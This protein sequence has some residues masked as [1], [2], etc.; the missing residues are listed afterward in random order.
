MNVRT[1]LIIGF[2]VIVILLWLIAFFTS[3]SY[4]NLHQQFLD[5][6]EEIISETLFITNIESLASET[7]LRTLNY[8][9]RGSEGAKLDTISLLDRL[10]G[11]EE[12]GPLHSGDIEQELFTAIDQFSFAI[13]T[14]ITASDNG[15]AFEDLMVLDQ[16]VGLPALLSL[17]QAA[18]AQKAQNSEE[19]AIANTDFNHTYTTGLHSIITSIALI[20]LIALTAA[21]L[22]TRSIVKPLH[23]LRKGTEM[24]A[25]GNLDFKVGTN[26]KDEIGQL[27]R[28]FDQM[29]EGL[30]TTMTSIDNLNTEINERKNVEK[31]LQKSEEKFRVLF[32]NAKDAI[33]LADAKTGVLI[34]VN[35]AGCELL[36]LPKEKIVGMHQSEVHPEGTEEKY[37]KLFREHIEKGNALSEDMVVQCADGTQVPVDISASLVELDGKPIVQGVFRNITGRKQAEAA[38]RES[39]E[40]F[41]VAFRS[42][43]HPMAI[44]SLKTSRFI[45][46]NDSF[47][48][49]TG[50]TR[51]EVIGRSAADL[52][53]WVDNDHR[54]RILKRIKEDGRIVNLE[55]LSRTKSGKVNTMLF[56]AEPIKVSGEDCMIAITT[57][58][59]ERR[60]AEEDLRESQEFNTSLLENSPHQI[61]VI[62]PDTSI[63]YV[64][65]KFEEVNGWTLDE[66]VG[67]KAPYPWWTDELKTEEAIE[68]FKEAIRMDVGQ[69]ETV[70]RKK[71]G[72]LYW[73]DLN[74]V[75]VKH[76]DELQYCLI[77]SI[78]VTERKKME[79][80]LKESEEKFFKAFRSSPN[81]IV[82]TTLKEGRFIEVNDS[83]TGLTGYTREEVI[84]NTAIDFNLW[85]DPEDRDRMLRILKRDGRVHNHEFNFRVKSG[86]KRTWTFSAELLDIG[87]EPCMI[88]MTL[89]ITEQKRAQ[90][91]LRESEE[92]SSSLMKNSAIPILV[93]NEDTSIR[94]VNPSFEKLTGFTSAEIVGRKAPM[95]WWTKDRNS[96]STDRFQKTI[97]NGASKLEKLFQKKNGE[98]FWVEVTSAPVKRNGK[99]VFSLLNWLDITG[100]KQM[101]NELRV[102]R[103][104]LEELV[105]E[106][107]AEL[108][109]VN[110]RLQYELKERQKAEVALLAAKDEAEKANQAKSEFLARTSHEIRTPIHGVMGTIN[111]V[112]DSKLE[113][114]QRQYLKMALTSA[115]TLLNIINDI[116]DLSKIEAGQLEPER[117]DFDLRTTIEDTLDSM[118]VT[119]HNKGLE[120]TCHLLGGVTTDLVGDPRQLRQVLVNLIGN[121]IKFT[122]KGEVAL[123]VEPVADSK[124]ETELH[125]TVRD[126]GIGIPKN[127][128]HM[129]FE[130][131]QQADGSINR[132]YGGTGLGLTISRHLI[133]QM[134]GHI[135]VEGNPKKG[136][137]FHFTGKFA[138]QTNGKHS[139]NGSKNLID[140][141]NMPLLLVDDNATNRLMLKDILV[142]WGFD[143]T[144]VASGP[145]ALQAIADAEADSTRYRI[146]LLDKTMGDMDGFT[147][148]EQILNGPTV[149]VDIIMML[150]PHS[151]SDDFARC[152]KLGISNYVVKPIRESELQRALLVTIGRA[153]ASKEKIEKKVEKHVDVPSLRVL[154]AEDNPTSQLIAR[155]TLEKIGH[156]VEIARMVRKR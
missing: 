107:T 132:K 71:N 101:E 144:D 27:S 28:A 22:T 92:F 59:T 23:E 14:L 87:T 127:K 104:N 109:D 123:Y 140:V 46:I 47:T 30:T 98:Q 36:C 122:E 95:P 11:I 147:V 84:G 17:Q 99:F 50:Y 130:P 80:A 38:I 5:V 115:E 110:N 69:V 108:T 29:T 13:T 148:A 62:N 97:L 64:N 44:S 40:K 151:V 45:E 152:Q 88:S 58:I 78:D 43:P 143:V 111:L 100:R 81:T 73:L 118:A 125:F 128:R 65:P 60:E 119:A 77:N 83:F 24:I 124:K 20:T 139:G 154:V 25:K 68:Q 70:A 32:E 41:S 53:F 112:L 19:L 6:E 67:I 66:I 113:H 39:E 57:D 55:Y 1:K 129:I 131:F 75:A 85:A 26:A 48:R 9:F 49:V 114:D 51:D 103:D 3:R 94:Y 21:V 74:W 150:P 31:A 82:I 61:V 54:D 149:P 105:R 126:T 153:P 2:S 96:G 116:L 120:L 79:E 135:W 52:N 10:E 33:F 117:E 42:S 156:H 90:E 121:S 133:D 155:K 34:D 56:S 142:R 136:S 76:D 86:E 72:E 35:P 145:T 7:Y 63:R 134:G 138:K 102:H 137:I 8:M 106:R 91:A 141:Q 146:I 12:T 4:Q 89:D 15:A 93:A 16:T 37:K 18:S